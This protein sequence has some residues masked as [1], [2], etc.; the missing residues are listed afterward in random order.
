MPLCAIGLN[1]KTAP[2]EVREQLVFG[3]DK[4]DEALHEL[5]GLNGVDESAILSTCNRTEVYLH[6]QTDEVR[7][8]VQWLGEYHGLAPDALKPYLYFHQDAAMVSHIFSVA[9]GL[10]S[11]ILGEPQI[12]GQIKD[13]YRTAR[14]SAS[15]GLLLERLFQQTFAVAKQV[16]TDTAIGSSPVSVAFAAVTLSKQIFGDL[17]GHTALLIGAGETI[18]LAARHLHENGLERMIVANRSIDRARD[19]ASQ[20]SGYAIG[21]HEIGAHLAEADIV[22]ASTASPEPILRLDTVKKAVKRRKHR[23]IFMVDLAV[24]RDIEPAVDKLD[25]IYL[26]TVDDLEQVVQEGLQSRQQAAEQARELIETHANHYM[27]WLHSLE[28]VETIREYRD[29]ANATRD[30]VL[31]KARRLLRNG[32]DPD[33]ALQFL[34][35]TLTNKLIHAPC[36]NLRQACHEQRTDFVDAAR[37][38]LSLDDGK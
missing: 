19:L 21:L 13:A 36:S 20:F 14:R 32:R 23:P 12:L 29:Q 3:P 34:A 17:A 7:A 37:R 33:Q 5:L 15:L 31:A 10:D 1:H 6:L 26:Y 27:G 25:D 8:I 24:P 2:V 4:I 16:R 22:I 35:H 30:A 38:L 11:M 18:E 28:A 9:S